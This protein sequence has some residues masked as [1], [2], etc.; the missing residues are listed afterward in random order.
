MEFADDV[1]AGVDV[2]GVLLKPG[3]NTRVWGLAGAVGENVSINKSGH[4]AISSKF[5]W[6]I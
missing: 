6:A 1:G 3:Q 5:F 2:G 4:M